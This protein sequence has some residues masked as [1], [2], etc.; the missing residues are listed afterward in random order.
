MEAYL[1]QNQINASLGAPTRL[2]SSMWLVQMYRNE[3]RSAAR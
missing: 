3:Y 2:R 1:Y